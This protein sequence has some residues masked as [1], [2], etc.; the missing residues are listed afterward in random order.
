[1]CFVLVAAAAAYQRMTGPTY[2]VKGKVHVGALEVRFSLPTS[3]SA[4]GNEEIRLATPDA[5]VRGSIELRRFPSNDPWS[6]SALLRQGEFLI[7]HIPHQPPAG[8]VMYRI[9]LEHGADLTPLTQDP[10]VL[11]YK[12]DVPLAIMIPHIVLM[13]L[14]MLF[15]TRAGIEAFLRRPELR[16]LS[17]WTVVTLAIGGLILGPLV[18]KFAFGAFWTG[19]PF[20]G[21]L[22]DNKTIVAFLFWAI[23]LWRLH[24]QRDA[25]AWA[26]AA[27][28]ILFLVYMIPHSLL[29]SQ[30]DYSQPP[31]P[32][33]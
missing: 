29:G 31:A 11:R 15:S 24:K 16:R 12:G 33:M 28:V 10:V 1:M 8:K 25:R 3:S 18:Q 20:G 9:Y 22:T 2:P 14:A 13:F 26:I 7:A 23:A 6:R 19:W 17:W 32:G 5:T 30:L 4:E 27:S 21:D